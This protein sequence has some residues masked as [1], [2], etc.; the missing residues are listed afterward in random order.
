MLKEHLFVNIMILLQIGA[1]FTYI[2]SKNW[3]LVIY[4][5]ACMSINIVVTYCL[6]K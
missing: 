1:I 2:S 5:I 6:G 4:W 3:P